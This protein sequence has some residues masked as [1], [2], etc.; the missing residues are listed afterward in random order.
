MI[1]F[2]VKDE[3]MAVGL[4]RVA[5]G[6][7]SPLPLM[8]DIAG[9]L[10]KETDDNFAA[11][12]RPAWM[13][14]APWAPST[15]KRRGTNAVML[16]DNGRLAGSIAISYDRTHATIGS[17]VRYAAI[18]QL[19]GTIQRAAYSKQVRHRTNAKGELL[20][21]AGFNGK[22]LVFAKG[23][24]KRALTRWFEVPAHAIT[25]PARPYLPFTG[26]GVLQPSAR[27]GVMRLT[28]DYLAS[29]VGPRRAK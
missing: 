26:Q 2:E 7:R 10:K 22:G 11:Q 23:S 4:A 20:R 24:H 3:G 25:I 18:H 21:T 29:L 15:L 5:E 13:G 6:Y 14:F 12:G 28:N 9:F 19:G 17:N 27:N 8:R 16:Q 1:D